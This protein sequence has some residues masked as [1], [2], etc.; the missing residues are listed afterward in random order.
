[1]ESKLKE[2]KEKIDILLSMGHSADLYMKEI[3]KYKDLLIRVDTPKGGYFDVPFV[4][5]F[6][7]G[8]EFIFPDNYNREIFRNI[9]KSAIEV[10]IENIEKKLEE[11][12][13]FNE[14]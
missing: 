5:K 2:Y 9:I 14:S 4:V 7:S 11:I 13:N 8:D 12:L 1:M 6:H 3:K 10:E